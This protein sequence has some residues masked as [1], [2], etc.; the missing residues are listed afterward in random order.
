[1]IRSQC[2]ATVCRATVSGAL[3]IAIAG[4][5][6]VPAHAQTQPS[7]TV[8][9]GAVDAHSHGYA[10][11]T[12]PF[13]VGDGNGAVRSDGTKLSP[14]QKSLIMRAHLEMLKNDA[15]E[16]AGLAKGLREVLDK[17]NTNVL[18]AEVDRRIDKIQKLARKIREETKDY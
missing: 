4:F 14:Q 9:Q 16:L 5:A 3:L 1:M 2:F 17:P 18:S 12:T 10:T 15:V 13:P 7:S 11:V 6:L 8:P